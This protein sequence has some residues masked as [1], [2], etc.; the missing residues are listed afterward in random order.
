MHT[1]IPIHKN[2]CRRHAYTHTHTQQHLQVSR[3]RSAQC[4]PDSHIHTHVHTCIHTVGRAQ[5][6][7]RHNV[8][9]HIDPFVSGKNVC[10]Y[11]HVLHT[12]YAC[13]PM[14]V[15]IYIQCV[16]IHI[17]R[18]HVLY[19]E[20]SMTYIIL[21]YMYIYIYIH[22]YIIFY[23]HILQVAPARPAVLSGRKPFVYTNHVYTCICGHMQNH[24][25]ANVVEVMYGCLYIYIYI[26]THTHTPIIVIYEHTHKF[27]GDSCF[28]DETLV[29][30][31][32][33]I[34]THQLVEVYIY[35]CMYNTHT[36]THISGPLLPDKE[37]SGQ[38]Y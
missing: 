33:H 23:T 19:Q 7:S 14:Y 10:V 22:A 31:S 37:R 24:I 13:I 38:V 29:H 32:A 17:H 9:H 2:T 25:Y 8:H 27:I 34:D 18:V 15:C 1:P 20:Q 6:C 21:L 35:A 28:P 30:A 16:Y 36:Y 11:I 26:Y 5:A 4:A 3:L 12:V